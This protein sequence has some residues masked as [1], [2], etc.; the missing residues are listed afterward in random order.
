MIAAKNVSSLDGG[1][2]DGR[3][4]LQQC[5]DF[6]GDTLPTCGVEREISP[7]GGQ[8]GRAI[9]ELGGGGKGSIGCVGVGLGHPEVGLDL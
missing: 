1:I 6:S 8:N 4:L 3:H 2:A 9:H 5:L 7:L